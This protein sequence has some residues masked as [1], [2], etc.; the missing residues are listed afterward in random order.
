MVGD[1]TS[2]LAEFCHASAGLLGRITT[3]VR[4]LEQQGSAQIRL[5]EMAPEKCIKSNPQLLLSFGCLAWQK[6]ASQP[7]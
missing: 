7:N 3:I 6:Q 5:T 2:G 1:I 4:S